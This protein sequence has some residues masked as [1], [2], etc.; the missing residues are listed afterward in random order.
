MI[1]G[2]DLEGIRN[3]L[4]YLQSLGITALY[5]NPIF[6]APGNHKYDTTDYLNID[7]YLGTNEEFAE[8][9]RVFFVSNEKGRG[10]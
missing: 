10:D 2:G 9:V 5:L 3:K 4:D 7:P 8:L 1:F 6:T